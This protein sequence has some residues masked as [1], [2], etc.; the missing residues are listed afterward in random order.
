MLINLIININEHPENLDEKGSSFAPGEQIRQISILA[1][2]ACQVQNTIFPHF[3]PF[4][5]HFS[6]LALRFSLA[7]LASKQNALQPILFSSF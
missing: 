7:L 5:F 1:F 6:V 3:S 2:P 4:T